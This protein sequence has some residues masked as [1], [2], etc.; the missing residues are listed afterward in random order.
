M[1]HRQVVDC[2]LPDATERVVAL[3]RQWASS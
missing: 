1:P 2:D 3:A